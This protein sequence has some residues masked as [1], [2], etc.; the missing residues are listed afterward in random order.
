MDSMGNTYFEKINFHEENKPKKLRN[1]ETFEQEK[2][3]DAVLFPSPSETGL[4]SNRYFLSH[5]FPTTE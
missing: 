4:L 2:E 1:K 3:K 5:V